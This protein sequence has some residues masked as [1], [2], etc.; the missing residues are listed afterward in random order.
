MDRLKG[1]VEMNSRLPRR[2]L[3]IPGWSHLMANL[4]I[5]ACKQITQ[6]PTIYAMLRRLCSFFQ[7]S[8]V[9]GAY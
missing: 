6:W 7:E 2:C 9:E 3:R 4:L 5:F 1:T 8:N